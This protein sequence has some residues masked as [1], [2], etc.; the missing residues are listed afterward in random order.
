MPLLLNESDVRAILT[1]Q[2]ALEAVEQSFRRLADGS[3]I[4]HSRRR[5]HVPGKSYLHYMAAA[6]ST[7]GYMGM[8]IYSSA[9]EGLRFLVPLFEVQSGD[10]AALIEADYLGQMRTGAASGV[11]TR[12]M[13]RTDARSVA[14]IGTG[15]QARTQLEAV[16]LVRKLEKIRAFG[17][18]RERREQFAKEMSERV[19]IP[20]TSVDSAEEA[21]R[22]ADIVI[23]STTATNPV[24]EG[25]WLSPGVHI[26]AIGANFPQKRELDTEAVNRSNV[27]AADSPE[28]SR[29]ESGDL[30]QVF[31]EDA[32]RW[33]AVRELSEIVAGKI[34]GRTSDD[35]ISLFKSNG[36][37]IEDIVV[38]GRIYELARARGMGRQI[39]IWQKEV[40]SAEGRGV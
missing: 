18:D 22:G 29:H 26:N 20:V 5:L 9:R 2:L 14:V 6:D 36:I 38:A 24:V 19:R 10:L 17:R 11:A 3:A 28:Q 27:I 31:G 25:R 12:V 16:S 7:G 34:P 1:M 37:A 33:A 35:Q 13:A 40:R 8:K 30:I 21:V 32:E 39:P 23:T 15:L 4:L